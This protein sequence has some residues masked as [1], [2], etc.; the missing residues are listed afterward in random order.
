[1]A[2]SPHCAH[3]P[4]HP[5]PGMPPEDRMCLTHGPHRRSLDI[6]GN[7]DMVISSISSRESVSWTLP[8]TIHRDIP[9]RSRRIFRRAS[10]GCGTITFRG[11]SGA[12]TTSA[13]P[14]PPARRGIS[15]TR[16]S[17]STSC[18][19][20]MPSFKPS[21]PPSSRRRD[22]VELHPDFWSWS[23]P[24]RRAWFVR[25]VMVRLSAA[26]D[27][28]GRPARRGALQR[29]RPPPAWTKQE[30]R[31]YGKL[32][33]GKN[34]TREAVMWFH[35]HGYGNAGA[36]SGHLI[37]DYAQGHRATAGEAS[38]PS[39]RP[40]TKPSRQPSREARKAPNS[41]PC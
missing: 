6:D 18:P 12:G 39:Y 11:S 20:P 26:G 34:G 21:A 17:P 2:R 10:N 36:T 32:V 13:P 29:H 23:L 7:W 35:N 41:G 37:P 30:A 16:N 38:T 33:Y 4:V 3:A 15:S 31:D 8:P 27:P 19:R 24:E 1:M 40:A 9:S 25:E 5:W 28:A 14:G 22:P